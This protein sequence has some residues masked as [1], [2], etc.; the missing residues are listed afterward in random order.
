LPTPRRIT[1]DTDGDSL[2]NFTLIINPIEVDLQQ[3]IQY[4]LVE[5]LDGQ[6]IAS[7]P[8]F[9]GRIRTLTWKNIPN[10]TP[11]IEMVSG[12]RNLEYIV[13]GVQINYRD[14]HEDDNN[15]QWIPIQVLS[16]STSWR[17]GAGPSNAVNSLVYESIVVEYVLRGM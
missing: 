14:L 5:T 1:F 7:L 6:P 4:E 11:Y 2:A 9:D 10:K 3:S 15:D 12:L 17:A 8:L 13:S 16:V